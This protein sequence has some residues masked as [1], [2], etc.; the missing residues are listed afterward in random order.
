MSLFWPPEFR[1][2]YKIFGISVQNCCRQTPFNNVAR[3]ISIT[4]KRH[5]NNNSSA[6][7]IF[8]L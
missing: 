5:I 2:G 6:T 7:L 3:T 4:N 1:S 8:T